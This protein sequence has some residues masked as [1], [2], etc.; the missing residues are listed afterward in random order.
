MQKLG[1]KS[2]ALDKIGYGYRSSEL[3][4]LYLNQNIVVGAQKNCLNEIISFE[5]PKYMF[6]LI[7]WKLIKIYI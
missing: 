2:R 6:R 5:L 3:I 4:F 7:E 1:N